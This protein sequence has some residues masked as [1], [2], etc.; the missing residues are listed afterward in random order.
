MSLIEKA[1][2]SVVGS[3]QARCPDCDQEI[4]TKSINITEGVALCPGC[5][6]LSRLSD[7]VRGDQSVQELIASPPS[8]CSVVEDGHTITVSVSLRS[9]TRFV[10]TCG[11]A[12]FWNGG[13]SIFLCIIIAGYYNH[14]IGPL[15]A[16]FPGIKNGFAELNDHRMDIGETLFMTLFFTPF[17][18]IGT[19]MIL[20][21]LMSLFGKVFVVIDEYGSYA[22]TGFRWVNWKRRFDMRQVRS[23]ELADT[24]WQSEGRQ[25]KQIKIEADKT[26]KFGAYLDDNQNRWMIAVLKTL[27]VPDDSNPNSPSALAQRLQ[28]I[29][30]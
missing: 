3:T 14:F 16:W 1:V 17:V 22:A 6:K 13:L 20:A 7:L 8:E 23:V 10:V 25:N 9:I 18:V 19:G 26:V 11:I 29:R 5:G 27:L 4:E 24:K 28:E 21:A 15:P 2:K 30:K 12:L